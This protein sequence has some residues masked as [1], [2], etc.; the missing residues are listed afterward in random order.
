M[1]RWEDT[2]GNDQGESQPRDSRRYIRAGIH[3]G[4]LW[5]AS[6]APTGG[7]VAAQKSKPVLLRLVDNAVCPIH[8]RSR[9]KECVVVG[10]GL[11]RESERA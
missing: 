2:D 3:K 7:T 11:A 10:A 4:D 8:L 9:I 1:R 5:E 6:N